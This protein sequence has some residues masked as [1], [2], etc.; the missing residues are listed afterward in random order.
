MAQSL[1]GLF[2]T[3]NLPLF[4]W[5]NWDDLAFKA[6]KESL[7]SLP[8]LEH[9]LPFFL[10]LLIIHHTQHLSAIISG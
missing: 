2:R 6:L 1:Y 5:E 10:F 8:V 3:T 4:I 7:I 9:H